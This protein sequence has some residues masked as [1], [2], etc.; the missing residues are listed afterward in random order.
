VTE[1]RRSRAQ[2]LAYENRRLRTVLRHAE[3]AIA[4]TLDWGTL[5]DRDFFALR[6]A[7]RRIRRERKRGEW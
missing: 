7:E 3:H 5:T 1:K 4:L 2:V 6:R